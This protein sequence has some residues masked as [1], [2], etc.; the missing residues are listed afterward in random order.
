MSN[1]RLAPSDAESSATSISW[2]EY[3]KSIIDFDGWRK[4][5]FN[6]ESLIFVPDPTNPSTLV[7]ECDRDGCGVII[8]TGRLCTGCKAEFKQLNRLAEVPFHKFL[9]ASRP[10][11]QTAVA[12]PCAVSGCVRRRYQRGL[13]AS[14]ASTYRSHTLRRR[15]QVTVSE[16]LEIRR[17]MKPLEVLA[18][19]LVDNCPY[20]SQLKGRLCPAHIRR[21]NYSAVNR[22]WLT[23][24]VW[25]E[26]IVEPYTDSTLPAK[27]AA[28]MATPFAL[29]QEPVRWEVIYAIQQR[30]LEG[31]AGLHASPLRNLYLNLRANATTSLAGEELCCWERPMS[32]NMHGFLKS[33]QRYVNEA[34]RLWLGHEQQNPHIVHYSDLTLRT[35][36][37]NGPKRPTLDFTNISRKWIADTVVSWVRAAPRAPAELGEAHRAWKILDVAIPSIRQKPEDL[38][39]SDMNI[40]VRAIFKSTSSPG[41]QRQLLRAIRRVIEHARV[42]PVLRQTWD[43]VPQDFAI[44]ATL[45]K[46]MPRLDNDSRYTDEPFRFVPQPI[47]DWTMDHL[48]LV[49]YSSAHK[50]AEARVMIYLQERC[51]RRSGETA[52][53]RDK[54]ISYDNDGAPYLE[55]RQGKPPYAKGQRLP[56]HQET[57]DAIR[58]WQKSKRANGVNS[59]WLF[60]SDAWAGI[61]QPYRSNIVQTRVRRFVEEVAAKAPFIGTVEGAEGNLINFDIRSID[62]YAFRH[63]FAQRLADAV[64]ENGRS[65]TPPDVLKSFMGHKSFITTMGYYDI[66]SK[67][68]R[69]A[70]SSLPTRKLDIHG[71]TVAA[72]AEREPYRRLGLTVG[73]CTEPQNV[74]SA[75]RSCALNHACESCPFFLVDPMDRE[76]IVAKRSHLEVQRERAAIINS[77]QYFLDFLE[78]RISDCDSVVG[79]IDRY[80]QQLPTKQ[81]DELIDI[82]ER[83]ADLRRRATAPRMLDL[84]TLLSASER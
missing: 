35:T 64:D 59:E 28:L 52:S 58:M 16:W 34:H 76:G 36:K 18:P 27:Y 50:T 51:G 21:F 78:S 79:G 61:D 13:C 53:L 69:R 19:C 9:Q 55:W 30:D 5:E 31:R 75:G 48:H 33:I 70:L 47:V 32:G 66:T 2:P 12:G 84:R 63:A 25:L 54:C 3:L 40:A 1:V 29:L 41:V 7:K 20:E 67:R 6:A 83:L 37:T 14:H 49:S 10:E 72:A 74:A 4:S 39:G 62:A 81:R 73:S 24:D 22:P 44:N 68:R 15:N 60:P 38:S 43:A 46:P 17:A 26:T 45:H 80:V 8:N 77:P 65:T 23:I 11:R 82:L 56:I 57:H 71:E 42:D